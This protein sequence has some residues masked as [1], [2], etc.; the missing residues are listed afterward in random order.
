MRVG[1]VRRVLAGELAIDGRA[2]LDDDNATTTDRNL[3]LM[4]RLRR[5]GVVAVSVG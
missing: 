5:N 3:G 4:G 1:A 2:F